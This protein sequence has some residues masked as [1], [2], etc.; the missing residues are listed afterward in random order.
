[1]HPPERKACIHVSLISSWPAAFSVAWDSIARSY[2][3]YEYVPF[4]Q[5]IHGIVLFLVG[6]SDDAGVGRLAHSIPPVPV[7]T[8]PAVGPVYIYTYMIIEEVRN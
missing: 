8:R 2:R 4:F 6:G 3:T 5:R 7:L 1:V